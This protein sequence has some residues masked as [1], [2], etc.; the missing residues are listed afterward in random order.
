MHRIGPDIGSYSRRGN[1]RL[2]D[3]IMVAASRKTDEKTNKM[4]F[5]W[6]EIASH[7]GVAD[8]GVGAPLITEARHGTVSGNESDLVAE[9]EQTLA[10][11]VQ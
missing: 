1:R 11:G 8:E 7:Q 6:T 2:V 5:H 10:D 9:R 3:S 4:V